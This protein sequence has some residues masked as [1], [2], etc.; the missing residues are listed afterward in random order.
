MD[1]AIEAPEG[2]A[3]GD[4][5]SAPW[6]GWQQGAHLLGAGRI[7]E[8]DEQSPAGRQ[9]AEQPGRLVQVGGKGPVVS[10]ECT[11]EAAEHLQRIQRSESGGG[12]VEAGIELAVR[13][14][15]VETVGQI[16]RE[17][18]LPDPGR[19]VDRRDH[20]RTV[21]TSGFEQRPE[22]FQLAVPTREGRDIEGELGR[23]RRRP[24]GVRLGTTRP[25]ERR[26]GG[27][28]CLMQ[29]L[30]LGAWLDAELLDE[31]SACVLIGL[32]RLG[33]TAGTI[34]RGHELPAQALTEREFHHQPAQVADQVAVAAQRQLCFDPLLKGSQSALLELLHRSLDR[35]RLGDVAR[36]GPRHNPSAARSSPA[37][38]SWAASRIAAL[39]WASSSSKRW[40]SNA[41]WGTWSR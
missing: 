6:A 38:W 33:L 21:L 3:A 12:A 35:R 15:G 19:A 4:Q 28:D 40:R 37:A 30:E 39:A 29:A 9:R 7:V 14:G 13:E 1:G 5:H 20:Y 26:V 27:E 11:Q 24:P 41:P 31:D 10:A 34:Q 18:R 17:G 22:P 8:H 23:D 36:T 16:D 2:S 25:S 32:Q